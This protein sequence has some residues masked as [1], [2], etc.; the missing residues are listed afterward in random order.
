MAE[1][2]R[3]QVA[4]EVAA[5]FEAVREEFAAVVAGEPAD[6]GA[7]LAVYQGGRRVVDLWAVTDAQEAGD[8]LAPL[9]SVTKGAAYLV[10]ALLVQDGVL[11][12]DREVA[13]YWPEFAAQGKSALT[14][15]ALLQHRAGVVGIPGGASVDE[16][17]D[18]PALAA[19]LAGQRPLW[20]PGTAYGYHALVIGALVGEVVRRATGRT[21]QEI[22]EERLR[23]PYGLDFY[24]GLPEQLAGRT[25]DVLP[26][27]PTPEQAAQLAAGVLGEAMR[28]AFNVEGTPDITVYG[29]SPLVRANGPASAGGVGNARGVAG[30]YAAAL[31]GLDG[32]PALLRPDTLARFTGER[33]AGADVVTGEVEHFLVGFETQQVRYPYLGA[34]AFGHCGAAGSEA[35]ADPSTGLT[36]AYARRLWAFPGG[37]APENLRLGEAVFKAATA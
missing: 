17:A 24:L 8:E 33:T 9:F 5:G 12:L 26:M 36:Y 35:W 18:E 34:D 11:D 13:H 4:G 1:T 27:R 19:R 2:A 23:S 37:A 20:Q 7:Q 29:N 32:G 16:L 10:T 6:T 14:L 21:V 28:I 3:V 15:R 30:L 22:Y 25:R 31:T